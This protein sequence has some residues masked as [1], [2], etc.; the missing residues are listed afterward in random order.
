MNGDTARCDIIWD[1]T[2]ENLLIIRQQ[3]RWL[4]DL[5]I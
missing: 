2:K 3:G 4:V 5:N 1:E